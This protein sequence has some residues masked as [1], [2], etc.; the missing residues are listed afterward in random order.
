MSNEY[1]SEGKFTPIKSEAGVSMLL[2]RMLQ[3][4]KF[5]L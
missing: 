1:S 4:G 2:S 3:N 5:C